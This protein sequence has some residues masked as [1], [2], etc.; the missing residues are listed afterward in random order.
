MMMLLLYP[1][2]QHINF[3]YIIL[4]Y[5]I[6]INASQFSGSV[7]AIGFNILGEISSAPVIKERSLI[8]KKGMHMNALRNT[9]Y[10]SLIGV[11]FGMI[12]LIFSIS[13][14]STYTFLLRS[15]VAAFFLLIAI[16]FLFFWNKSYVLNGILIAI[17]YV[18]AIV[19]YDTINGNILTFG[20]LYLSGGIP[21]MAFL[22]GLY[23][24]PKLY[25][26]VKQTKVEKPNLGKVI[27]YSPHFFSMMR[28]GSIGSI[29]GMVPF[30][31]PLLNSNVA[32]DLEKIFHKKQN[33]EDALK[34]ITAA[35]TANN[36]GQITVL[37][38]LLILGIAI[39]P[40]EII[41]LQLIE[42]QFWSITQT[43][44]WK[45]LTLLYILIPIGCIFTAF[46]CYNIVRTT[47]QFFYSHIQLILYSI[48]LISTA[49]I[50]YMGYQS[51]QT[52]YY[53]LVLC[54]ST[55]IG[56]VLEKK[57]IDVLPLI[58]VFLLENNY[59]DVIERI[60]ILY[61]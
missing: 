61:L 60:V 39:Q 29:L 20:N 31:G 15:D 12:V 37:I 52:I 41:L 28:G 58:I 46:L 25:Q 33:S 45:F 16:F 53:F 50:L 48:L 3:I 30:I 8:V 5:A 21:P 34:R 4:F 13:T 7:S 38:P 36:A 11:L 54:V 42:S 32:Y 6:M 23:M 2:L 49:S 44:N 19:G 35:E 47:M 55:A 18:I 9:V 43:Y 56:L 24:I 22:F 40:S 59:S 14:A 26:M 27:R 51:D 1:V 17:G 10:G 57:K